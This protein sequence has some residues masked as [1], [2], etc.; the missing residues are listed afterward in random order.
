MSIFDVLVN[1]GRMGRRESW[2]S[3]AKL[4]RKNKF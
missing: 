1:I 3:Q 2:S 4:E